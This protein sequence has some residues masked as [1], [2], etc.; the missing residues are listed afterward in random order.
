MTI[1]LT[2]LLFLRARSVSAS[3]LG[4]SSTRRITL[5]SMFRFLEVGE[6]EVEGRPLVHGPLGPGATPVT[7]DDALDGGEA[8]PSALELVAAVETLERAEQLAGVRH[9][10]ARAVVADEVDCLATL[11]L[12]PESDLRRVALRGELPGVAQKVD[13]HDFQQ[14]L[15]AARREPVLDVDRHRPLAIALAQLS[16]DRARELAQV[17]GLA[18]HLGSGDA[19][20]LQHVVNQLGHLLARAAHLPQIALALLVQFVLVVFE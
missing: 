16:D 15:V 7:I 18:A 1:S 11:L 8:Y 3:S 12:P 13:E 19:R 17:D 2:M 5:L 4:L 10:E 9:V 14:S 6:G 20:E